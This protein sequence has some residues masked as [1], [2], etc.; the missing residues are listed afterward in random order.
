VHDSKRNKEKNLFKK[1]SWVSHSCEIEFF[2]R[3][4][5]ME[6]GMKCG[7]AVPSDTFN[8]TLEVDGNISTKVVKLLRRNE[9]K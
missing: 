7:L 5:Q 3:S 9:T 4:N 6:N 2:I 1:L 8:R